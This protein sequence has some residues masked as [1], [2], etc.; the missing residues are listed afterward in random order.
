MGVHVRDFGDW[1]VEAKQDQ[2]SSNS[3]HHH[4]VII[5]YFI[6]WS[7]KW[8]KHLIDE[9]RLVSVCDSL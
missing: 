2:I 6:K 1:G 9:E 5:S 4:K 7:S 8:K 3:T